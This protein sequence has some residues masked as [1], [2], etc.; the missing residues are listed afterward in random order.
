MTFGEAKNW[1]RSVVTAVIAPSI[2]GAASGI[3]TVS[4]L[5]ARTDSLRRDV[6]R[7][8]R[9]IQNL[10]EYHYGPK[11]AYETKEPPQDPAALE[12][13]RPVSEAVSTAS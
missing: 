9:A 11:E 2:I 1:G 3:A 7:N 12:A 4:S 6:Q 10:Q 13:D 5:E 8:E